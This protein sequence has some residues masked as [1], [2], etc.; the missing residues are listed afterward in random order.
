MLRYVFVPDDTCGVTMRLQHGVVVLARERG[1]RPTT[2]L[3]E[4]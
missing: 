1:S 2:N 3:P 4:D